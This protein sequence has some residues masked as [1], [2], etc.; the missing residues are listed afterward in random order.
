LKNNDKNIDM[1]PSV[2]RKK[3]ED[4]SAINMVNNYGTYE[5]QNTADTNNQYPAIAQGF[6]EK[7]VSRDCEN[8]HH[9]KKWENRDE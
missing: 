4:E 9:G 3:V 1:E 8:S 5:V 7:I 6:N 2:M